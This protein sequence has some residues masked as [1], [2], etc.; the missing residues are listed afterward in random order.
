MLAAGARRAPCRSWRAPA[1]ASSRG[2]S[3][4]CA[5]DDTDANDA[6]ALPLYDQ[7]YY[8]AEGIERRYYYYVDLQGRLFLDGCDPKNIATSLK[9]GRFLDFFFTRLRARDATTPPRRERA[10]SSGSS[11]RG[12]IAPDF[13]PSFAFISPCGREHNFVRAA[14]TPIV[15][16]SLVRAIAPTGGPPCGSAPDT[17]LYGHS[18]AQPFAPKHLRVCATSGRIY[19]AL[20]RASHG[21][22]YALLRSHVALS[23]AEK[24]TTG[25]AHGGRDS[26]SDESDA[27]RFSLNWGG[28]RHPLRWLHE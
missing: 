4:A 11:V 15:F 2:R 1:L 7:R 9:D 22:P 14:D 23:L 12:G 20:E 24:L 5:S 13:A 8:D 26:G 16:H 3:G 25:D 21:V 19:H 27:E 6:A 10:R 28:A 17:L 18:L